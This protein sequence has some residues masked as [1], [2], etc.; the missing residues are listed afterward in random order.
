MSDSANDV[1]PLFIAVQLVRL[2]DRAKGSARLDYHGWLE[3]ME[4]PERDAR[5]LAV[6][7]VK[8]RR[9]SSPKRRTDE[10]ESLR[11]RLAFFERDFALWRG[12]FSGE[13][14][15]IAK[16]L[17][18]LANLQ[19]NVSIELEELKSLNQRNEYALQRADGFV[20][21]LRAVAAGEKAEGFDG[22]YPIYRELL[23]IADSLEKLKMRVDEKAEQAVR[24]VSLMT[25]S[26]DSQSLIDLLTGEP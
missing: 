1:G 10:P 19:L 23:G 12:V 8:G 6:D 16:F 25:V 2:R 7:S 21:R 22:D 20:R 13:A 24:L 3:P 17:G 15:T 5:Q 11:W 26:V 18:L 14:N 9:K 4:G